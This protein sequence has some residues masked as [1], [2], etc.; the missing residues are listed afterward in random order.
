MNLAAGLAIQ[1][2]SSSPDRSFLTRDDF[3]ALYEDFKELGIE[4]DVVDPT[5]PHFD[6]RR[7]READ[8]YMPNSDGS[9][10]INLGEAT[11]YIAFLK[12]IGAN[13]RRFRVDIEHPCKVSDQPGYMGW[14]PMNPSC[15]RGT[16][17]KKV[18]S[19]W[20]HAPGMVSYLQSLG[21]ADSAVIRH[22]FEHIARLKGYSEEPIGGYDAKGFPSAIHYV[23][24]FFNRFDHHHTGSL[25]TNEA[26]EMSH[27][28]ANDIAGFSGV[29]PTDLPTIEAIFTYIV[30]NG[31]SPD[32][33]DMGMAEVASWMAARPMW[34]INAPR[35]AIY[36]ALAV[37]ATAALQR[38]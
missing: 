12:S 37:F 15:F 6:Q 38:P 25:D 34:N 27:I 17:F 29:D 30:R 13:A 9:G 21:A 26:V 24:T 22:D 5:V 31:K 7:F 3:S 18:A 23:E 2:Y 32:P 35:V 4:L 19:Y 10:Q 16:Y 1:A 36:R 14:L 28:F 11:Y 20:S 33:K 8:L